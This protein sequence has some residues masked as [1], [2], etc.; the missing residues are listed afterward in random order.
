LRGCAPASCA[1]AAKIPDFLRKS[2]RVD[3]AVF[4]SSTLRSNTLRQLVLTTDI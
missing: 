4:L 2:R 3:M 1:E